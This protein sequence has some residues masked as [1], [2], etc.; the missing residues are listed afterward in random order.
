MVRGLGDA[1]EWTI[2][3]DGDLLVLDVLPPDDGFV[4]PVQEL[5]NRHW[6]ARVIESGAQDREDGRD[7]TGYTLARATVIFG[8]GKVRG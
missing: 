3:V 8:D 4:R 5:H 2:A 1:G 7:L 6:D